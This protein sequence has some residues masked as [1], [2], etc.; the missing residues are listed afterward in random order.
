[1]GLIGIFA[2]RVPNGKLKPFMMANWGHFSFRYFMTYADK[3]RESLQ[4]YPNQ[5]NYHFFF[6]FSCDR[7]FVIPCIQMSIVPV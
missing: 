1:M 4:K 5:P 7:L 6:L 2:K 3:L